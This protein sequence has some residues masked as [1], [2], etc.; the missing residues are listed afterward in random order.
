VEDFA[1][2][3]ALTICNPP[4]RF[5]AASISLL[6]LGQV[7]LYDKGDQRFSW[8]AKVA[9]AGIISA[10]VAGALLAGVPSVRWLGWLEYLD[11]LALVK[12][13]ITMV[14]YLPQ[15]GGCRRRGATLPTA[16]G[17]ALPHRLPSSYISLPLAHHRFG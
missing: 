7:I 3:A 12:L 10:A 11:A 9:A 15:V 1:R 5:Q 14:K 13:G 17:Q 2:L 8:P 16:L 6:T 4:C